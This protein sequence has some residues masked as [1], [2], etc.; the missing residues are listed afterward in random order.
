[1]AKK[2][3]KKENDVGY[4][5]F[6]KT[7]GIELDPV[8]MVLKAHLLAEY[9]LDQLIALEIPRGDVIV[10]RGFSFSQ[11][12][13]ILKSLNITKNDI[14]DLLDALNQLRNRCAH[15]MEYAIS[16]ADIDR[17]GLPQGKSYFEL[18]EEYTGK[19][20]IRELLNFTLIGIIAPLDGLFIH[21]KKYHKGISKKR[22]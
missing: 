18:K 14:L 3:V 17:I 6:I 2:K 21:V 4:Q 9:Y 10:D 1:M 19:K 20:T 7:A 8:L 16:E 11:K 5:R 12:L 22:K 13:T 15:D